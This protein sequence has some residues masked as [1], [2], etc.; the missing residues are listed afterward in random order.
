MAHVQDA[1]DDATA[2]RVVPA[3]PCTGC[4]PAV[5]AAATFTTRPDPA[6][7]PLDAV[8]R[9]PDDASYLVSG[10]S[11]RVRTASG[12]DHE[13]NRSAGAIWLSFDG[14]VTV[15]ELIQELAAEMGAPTEVVDFDV[16]MAVLEL[17]AAGLVEVDLEPAA[18]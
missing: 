2:P 5:A 4:G 16:R 15:G 13:L 1:A 14:V 3:T 9:R 8:V 17:R 11:L 6:R 10:D 18:G 7:V 12:A